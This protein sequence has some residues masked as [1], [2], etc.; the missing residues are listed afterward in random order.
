MTDNPQA[1][2]WARLVAEHHVAVYRYCYRFVGSAAD[3]EDL[4]QQTFLAAVQKLDQL[5]DPASERPWLLT[6]ARRCFLK[7]RRKK[8]PATAGNL[9]LELDEYVETRESWL[10][11]LPDHVDPERLQTGINS[12]SDEYKLV[13]TM[14]YFEGYSYREIAQQLGVAD[15]TVMSRLS[16]AKA[17]LRSWLTQAEMQAAGPLP[18]ATERLP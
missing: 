6:I 3:A 9:G 7:L 16:R 15:G 14:F 13:L 17:R 12:L 18:I 10:D 1:P 8:Q 11:R 2:D 5:R 4:T